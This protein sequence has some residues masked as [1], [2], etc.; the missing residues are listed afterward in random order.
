MARPDHEAVVD[1]PTT[2]GADVPASAL[3]ALDEAAGAIAGV[4]DLEDVLQLIVDRV[5][6]LIGARYAAL[7]IVTGDG[8]IDR[9]ITSGISPEERAAI[10]PLP[11]GHGLLGLI[12]LEGR[13]L[14]IPEIAGH[15]ASVGF[16]A[17]HPPMTTFLG[18]PVTAQGRPI[19]NFYLTDKEGGAEFTAADQR[20]A[21]MFA[22]H[23]GIAIDNARLHAQ[24][25]SLAVIEERDRISRDLHDGIIQSLYGV[26]LALE[27]VTTLAPADAEAKVDEAI[28]AI[29]V[30][31]RDIRHFI[32]GLS[33]ETSDG[34]DLPSALLALANELRHNTLVDVDAAIDAE[35][36]PGL[37]SEAA[38]QLLHLVREA[39]SN[40][41]RHASAARI[42][43]ALRHSGDRAEIEVADDGVGF[44]PAH[45][46]STDHR[47]LVNMRARAD[48]AGAQLLVESR[49]G[50]GTRII[51]SVPRAGRPG[52][53]FP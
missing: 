18:V 50:G 42:A 35:A 8:W 9:F 3:A 28:D 34:R 16:P 46:R 43:I 14:R 29:H 13:A 53:E 38:N 24:V 12:I 15:P 7:G 1:A 10:G 17:N 40:A 52:G 49:P 4:L 2:L 47:G 27:D 22:R 21:E 6:A 30:A 19:G 23:A 33:G 20:L 36:D 44:D 11:T 41:S 37:S 5:R 45:A 51:V 32:H 48:A 26:S 31:I 39:L 25:R